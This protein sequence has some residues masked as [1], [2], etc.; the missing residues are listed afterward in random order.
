MR[1]RENKRVFTKE[2]QKELQEY[3]KGRNV[4][5][6]GLN[7]SQ[8]INVSTLVTRGLL[9]HIAHSLSAKGVDITYFD[10]FSLLFNKIEHAEFLLDQDLNR[11]EIKLIQNNGNLEAIR[12]AMKNMHKP[13]IFGEVGRLLSV[14]NQPTDEDFGQGITTSLAEADIAKLILSVG[15]NDLMRILGTNPYDINKDYKNREIN[16]T[17]NYALEAAKDPRTITMVMDKY[18]RLIEKAR[19][20]N[21]DMNIYSLGVYK[22]GSLQKPEFVTFSELIEKYDEELKK[23]CASEG[24]TFIDNKEGSKHIGDLSGFHLNGTGIKILSNK[25]LQHM[26]EDDIGSKIKKDNDNRTTQELTLQR[27]HLSGMIEQVGQHEKEFRANPNNSIPFI[28]DYI[29]YLE[30]RTEEIAQEDQTAIQVLRKSKEQ[31]DKRFI[32]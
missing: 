27:E 25:I 10:C 21:N 11:A 29:D 31:Y 3:Y 7:D 30:T 16:N 2:H 13:L 5:I 8:G 23:L 18:K 22:T 26:W 19:S 4:V 14:G 9:D 28:G 6:A 20:I 1:E 17:Y 15:P 24:I 12:N 32:A